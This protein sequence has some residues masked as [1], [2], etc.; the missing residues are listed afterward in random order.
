MKIIQINSVYKYSSTG[1][2]VNDIH[3]SI[4]SN[5]GD[6]LIIYG[7]KKSEGSD[8]IK[9][10]GSKIGLLFHLFVTRLFD[11]HGRASKMATKRAIKIIDSHKPD[12]VHL[13]NIHGYYLN[14]KL[15]FKFLKKYKYKIVWTF[16]DCWPFT[17]HCAHY[18]SVGCKKW[19]D[20]CLKCPSKKSYPTSFL[21][22]N[23][24]SNF[25]L[26]RKLFSGI[27]NLTV[28]TPSLWLKGEVLK[29][30]FRNNQIEVINNG[31]D[32]DL[33]S[34]DGKNSEIKKTNNKQFMILGVSSIWLSTKGL[35]HFNELAEQLNEDE[36]I[37]LIGKISKKEQST[38]AK[39]VIY[40]ERTNSREQLAE[41]YREADIFLNPTL[42]DTF[43]TV[44]IEALA[45]GTP[46]ITFDTGGSP[47]IIDE[48]TGI[49]VQEKTA[50]ALRK[51][52]DNFKENRQS[53]TSENCRKRAEELY[54]KNDRFDDYIELYKKIISEQ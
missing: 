47:E 4:L 29:S 12:I 9:F 5:N 41:L 28:V 18:T 15:L 6:S 13:H 40:I 24:K 17:G 1:G 27:Q 45:C 46:V 31:I 51:A 32:L 19:L 53:F 44:N 14:Y 34:Q 49:V 16:H 48:K 54:N 22:D 37:V 21:F 26:K 50:N 23:S 20:G 35:R 11:M 3:S 42:E 7:R 36:I 39:R 8:K 10:I 25:K 38:L 2:I 43:P 33:W 30:F 52:I